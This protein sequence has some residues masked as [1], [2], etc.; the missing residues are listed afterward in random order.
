MR[1]AAENRACAVFHQHE[2]GDPHRDGAV[3]RPE[4]DAPRAARCR[5]RASPAVSSAASLVP[6]LRHSATKAAAPASRAATCGGQRMF[7]RQRQEAHAEQRVRPGGEHLHIGNARLRLAHQ[8]KADAAPSLRPIHLACISRTRS[9][10]RSSVV[11][12]LLS[13]S[14]ANVVIFR[15]HCGQ[16]LLLHQRALSASRG[17][18]SPARW[19]ARCCPPG[20]SSR[21]SSRRSARPAC[22]NAQEQRCC[23]WP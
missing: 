17:R 12:R 9:G 15:N 8:R 7:G 11:E 23:C 6:M 5:S 18:R 21:C 14:G 10:Q 20:P 22:I 19:P 16:L 4:T 3:I 13:R 1:R 2:I